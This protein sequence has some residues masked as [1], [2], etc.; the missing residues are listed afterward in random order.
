MANVT[1]KNTLSGV[2]LT[3]PEDQAAWMSSQW[4]VVSAAPVVQPVIQ[5]V[6]VQPAPVAAP[7]VPPAQQLP[8]PGPVSP[9]TTTPG[10]YLFIDTDGKYYKVE[11]G[12]KTH[13][14]TMTEVTALVKGGFKDFGKNPPASVP[15]TT[16]KPADDYTKYP[17][18]DPHKNYYDLRNK[19]ALNKNLDWTAPKVDQ[20]KPFN[21]AIGDPAVEL[22]KTKDLYAYLVDATTKGVNRGGTINKIDPRALL[23]IGD[24]QGLDQ[25]TVRAATLNP[26]LAF[27]KDALVYGGYTKDD[28]LNDLYE[29][30]T[31]KTTPGTFGKTIDSNSAGA[32]KGQGLINPNVTR[33]P[34]IATTFS[35]ADS[36][37]VPLADPVDSGNPKTEPVVT[38]EAPITLLPVPVDPSPTPFINPH[39][40][41][42]GGDKTDTSFD[43][44]LADLKA[45]NE[46]ERDT[47]RYN[48]K[49]TQE[50]GSE[51][52]AVAV[53]STQDAFRASGLYG[54]GVE[55]RGELKLANQYLRN[56]ED[57]RRGY[58]T[59]NASKAEIDALPQEQIDRLRMDPS[60]EAKAAMD[61]LQRQ[62]AA[63][64][65][66]APVPLQYTYTDS[67][68]VASGRDINYG[69][70][71]WD[72]L[73]KEQGAVTSRE[74]EKWL[75][76]EARRRNPASPTSPYIHDAEA[77][78]YNPYI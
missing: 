57:T 12:Q 44:M 19:E 58:Y 9:T 6:V 39:I 1:V 53:E 27:Y 22:S 72:E 69:G 14:G 50:R 4:Q 21:K 33:D 23:L 67:G 60:P 41:E 74:F 66:K 61:D 30:F 65:A 16:T 29:R 55:A 62:I 64:W 75:R 71:R 76:D 8:S 63:K 10:K 32:R 18:I 46:L 43:L 26:L 36:S 51:D 13:V 17:G 5:P 54:S 73:N 59:G 37:D 34:W 3:I 7:Y 49:L 52:K 15:A 20:A 48:Y 25:T 70:T 35:P 11:N 2:T 45:K 77:G 47:A 68:R 56:F 42:F 31:D 28:I 40:T 24:L 78:S 38:P